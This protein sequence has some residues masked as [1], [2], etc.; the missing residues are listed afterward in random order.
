MR[1]RRALGAAVLSLASTALA[2]AQEAPARV[3]VVAKS[4]EQRP[5]V[6]R[7]VGADET[8]IRIERAGPKA[9]VE[10]VAVP[11]N[12]VTR[13]EVSRR[14][15]RKSLGAWVGA[16]VGAGTAAVILAGREE[17]IASC[18][19]PP[20]WGLVGGGRPYPCSNSSDHRVPI[21]LLA[22]PAGAL[23]G[24]L[25]APGEKWEGADPTTVRLGIA[26]VAGGG[27]QVLLRVSF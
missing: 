13:L 25:V 17:G 21:A 7:L 10:T 20:G 3:R 15:S 8:T 5:I 19:P 16:L 12:A 24:A 26:P 2:G 23:L 14:K 9:T 27:A 6:G 18:P 1:K 22:V 11:R 4:V